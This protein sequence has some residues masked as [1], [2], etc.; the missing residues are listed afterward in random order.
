VNGQWQV[1][2]G[3]YQ[4]YGGYSSERSDGKIADR[5]LFRMRLRTQVQFIASETLSSLLNFE[6]GDLTYGE[7][8]GRLDADGVAVKVKHAYIDWTIPGTQIK[9]RQGIQGLRLPW[10]AHGN[11]VMDADVAG[12]TLSTQFTPEVGLTVFWARPYD[13]DRMGTPLHNGVGDRSYFD[14]MDMFGVMLPIKTQAVRLTP[15]AMLALIGKDSGYYG[16]GNGYASV[17]SSPNDGGGAGRGRGLA[18]PDKVD[19]QTYGWWAGTTFELPLINPFFVKIDLITGGLSTGDS[20][21]DTWGYY[22]GFDIGYKFG[23]GSPS[24]IGWYSSG[25]KDRDDRG[26]LPIVSDDNGF[27][28]SRYGFSNNRWRSVDCAVSAAGLGMWGLGLRVA[29]VSFLPNLKHTPQVLFFRGTNE[30]DAKATVRH[31]AGPFYTGNIWG[32]KAA[33]MMTS[34][35]GW[36]FSL[37]NEYK[38]NENFTIGLDFSYVTLKMGPQNRDTNDTFAAMLGFQYAF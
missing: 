4:N 37:E 24:V 17:Q 30:G 19:K 22:G 13:A 38:V 3:Y 23:W 14:E 18:R 29:D 33:Y 25:D 31:P 27:L 36:E 5:T 11:M 10:V 2:Y 35:S 34:D 16:A 1:H 6:I 28:I 12:V 32:S 26:T 21:S 7:N 20:Y 15:W 8:W 9:T